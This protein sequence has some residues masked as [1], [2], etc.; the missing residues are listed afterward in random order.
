M[1]LNTSIRL[2]TL[3]FGQSDVG[4]KDWSPCGL[5]LLRTPEPLRFITDETGFS[6][7]GSVPIKKQHEDEADSRGS[8]RKSDSADASVGNCLK[9]SNRAAGEPWRIVRSRA[10]AFP[11]PMASPLKMDKT[12]HVKAVT[13]PTIYTSLFQRSLDSK[14]TC[15]SQNNSL[16]SLQTCFRACHATGL[17]SSCESTLQVRL[18]ISTWGKF[19]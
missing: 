17:D 8:C 15:L 14:Q 1:F 5:R 3:I 6:Q 9:A 7:Q 13:W 4:D 11:L 18:S 16:R 12:G 10:P 2:G 19:G